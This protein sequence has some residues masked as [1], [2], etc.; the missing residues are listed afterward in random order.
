[1]SRMHVQIMNQFNQKSHE[2]KAIELSSVIGSSYNRIAVKS[3]ISDF[4]A[5]L[6]TNKEILDELLSYPEDSPKLSSLN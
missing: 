6:L 1:M 2:Y 4:V 3:A 5:L